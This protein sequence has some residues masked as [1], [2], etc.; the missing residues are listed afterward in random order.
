MRTHDAAKGSRCRRCPFHTPSGGCR[1]QTLRSGRCGD[2]VY[3]LVRG[4]KQFRRLWVKPNDPR[5]PPQ[6]S[7][8]ARLGAASKNYSDLLTDEQQDACIAAR[9]QA[10]SRPRCGDSGTLTGQQYYVKGRITQ[11]KS[12]PGNAQGRAKPVQVLQPQ[13][14]TRPTSDPRQHAFSMSPGRHRCRP[15]LARKAA[16]RR[17]NAEYRRPNPDSP[18]PVPQFETPV[19]SSYGYYRDTPGTMPGRTSCHVRTPA[20]SRASRLPKCASAHR[21]GATTAVWRR[22]RRAPGQARGPPEPAFGLR[23]TIR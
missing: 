3:Y 13:V 21:L 22:Q 19:P 10:K 9:G 18:L 23:K 1:D 15:R 2:W 7:C 4:S 11:P 8:R 6:L 12:Q 17:K 20:A 5:T 16:G 14:L